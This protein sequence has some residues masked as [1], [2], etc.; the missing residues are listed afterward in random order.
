MRCPAKRHPSLFGNYY[1]EKTVK[2]SAIPVQGA[3]DF[4]F[5]FSLNS[6]T[7]PSCCFKTALK[8]RKLLEIIPLSEL[9]TMDCDVKGY[10][11]RRNQHS[12]V[13][14]AHLSSAVL[15]PEREQCC[16]PVIKTFQQ[17]LFSTILGSFIKNQN[18]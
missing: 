11:L 7:T 10:V 8:E 18:C 16:L 2:Y 12:I 13:I 3:F 14:C 1:R 4:L 15:N 9:S 6:H 5:T 17:N